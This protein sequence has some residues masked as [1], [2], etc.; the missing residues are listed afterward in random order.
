VLCGFEG[1]TTTLFQICYK[2]ENGPI[3][4][5]PLGIIASNNQLLLFQYPIITQGAA[6]LQFCLRQSA[7]IQTV[8]SV[9]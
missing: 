8:Y 2:V 3:L 4:F 6:T 7:P 1:V 9:L 5:W